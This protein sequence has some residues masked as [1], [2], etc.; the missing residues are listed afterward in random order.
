MIIT[1]RLG[2]KGYLN[3]AEASSWTGAD[4]NN[5]IDGYVRVF[6]D[7]PFIFPIGQNGVYRPI[8]ISGG[9]NTSAAYY[10]ASAPVEKEVSNSEGLQISTQEYWE[11]SGEQPIFISLILDQTSEIARLA[12]D[13][14]SQ[15]RIIGLKNDSWQEIESAID[16]TDTRFTENEN[17]SK[18]SVL[19]SNSKIIPNEYKYF[20]LG[21][22]KPIA[23]TRSA[24]QDVNFSIYP[25][26]VQSEL[27]VD[28]A[29]IKGTRG[30]LRIYNLYGQLMSEQIY[31][32]SSD[33][34]FRFNTSEFLNG[35][36][37]LYIRIDHVEISKK[38]TVQQLY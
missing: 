4:S 2:E 24:L 12:K 34:I 16:P 14:Y 10:A 20:T 31:D 18:L 11:I 32:A 28:L 36:Y 15:V 6:H 17:A 19:S 26:P 3:F 27:S 8:S 21:V 33:P 38:F 13:D 5:F 37:E 30:S 23:E 7:E 35:M 9:K 25:N 29:K 1:E 22:V